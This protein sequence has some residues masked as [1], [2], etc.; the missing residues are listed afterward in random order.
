[1]SDFLKRRGPRLENGQAT[2]YSPSSY[3][4]E[5][6]AKKFPVLLE[7]LTRE[8]W[9]PGQPREKGSI[10]LFAEEGVFKACASDKDSMEVAFVT[11]ATFSGLLDALEKGMAN[12]SLDWR[13]STV[14]KARKRK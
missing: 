13:L 12:G 8:F 10:I 14:G 2:G 6:F 1:M 9:E 4:D 5:S 7:F 3:G 11:K